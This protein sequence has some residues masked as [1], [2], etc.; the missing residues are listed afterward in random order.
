MGCDMCSVGTGQGGRDKTV[1]GA[2]CVYAGKSDTEH[3][4]IRTDAE[5]KRQMQRQVRVEGEGGWVGI[6]GRVGGEDML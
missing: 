4:T 3:N 1:W 5:G 2:W 6:L